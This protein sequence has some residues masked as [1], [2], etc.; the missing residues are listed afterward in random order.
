MILINTYKI[1]VRQIIHVEELWLAQCPASVSVQV[2]ICVYSPL[3]ASFGSR[4]C[5][6]I[7]LKEPTPQ[8]YIEIDNT[9]LRTSHAKNVPKGRRLLI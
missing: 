9:S 8:T 5:G 6:G 1:D 7:L 4:N 2:L 3:A